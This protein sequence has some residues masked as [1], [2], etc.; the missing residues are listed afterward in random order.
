MRLET[1]TS[2][3]TPQITTPPDP[4]V[5]IYSSL[6][7]DTTN[8]I[9][10]PHKIC[11]QS[12]HSKSYAQPNLPNFITAP[13]LTLPPQHLSRTRNFSSSIASTSNAV[14]DDCWKR[15]NYTLEWDENEQDRYGKENKDVRLEV[16]A[17]NHLLIGG[18]ELYGALR[19][20]A[21]F[22]CVFVEQC[23]MYRNW[24]EGRMNTKS[25]KQCHNIR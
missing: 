21:K 5:I 14:R 11:Q 10:A 15:G 3:H 9:S 2:R 6:I 4:S 18:V 19:F 8:I 12:F 24:C 1:D 13:H 22:K 17:A 16:N 20:R 23:L 25:N 7:R